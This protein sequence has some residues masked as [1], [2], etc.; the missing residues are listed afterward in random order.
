VYSKGQLLG[1]VD[2]SGNFTPAPVVG[3]NDNNSNFTPF[4]VQ[5]GDAVYRGGGSVQQVGGMAQFSFP[6]TGP[7]PLAAGSYYPAQ[8]VNV[9]NSGGYYFTD[10][11]GNQAYVNSNGSAVNADGSPYQPPSGSVAGTPVQ[12]VTELPEVVVTPSAPSGADTQSIG[13]VGHPTVSQTLSHMF[14]QLDQSHFA[15]G[16]NGIPGAAVAGLQQDLVNSGQGGI[17]AGLAYAGLKVLQPFDTFGQA[18]V[19][20]ALGPV[21]GK[22][23]GGVTTYL[24]KVPGLS[25]LGTDVTGAVRGWFGS[26]GGSSTAAEATAAQPYATVTI[27]YKALPGSEAE[28]ARQLAGQE[29][30]INELTAGEIR[31]NIEAFRANGR[32]KWSRPVGQCFRFYK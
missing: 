32:Q 12:G 8:T 22:V 27:P 25:A 17:G 6:Q 28:F 29:A 20:A 26:A 31:S 3:S 5:S 1:N 7:Y 9:D 10:N 11:N 24:P 23:I 19:G 21:F 2:A 13:E 4:D 14:S 30:G 18:G 15:Q 16:F